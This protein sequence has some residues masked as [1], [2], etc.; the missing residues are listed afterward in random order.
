MKIKV[1]INEKYEEDEIIIKCSKLSE[2][3]V[4]L[5]QMISNQKVKRTRANSVL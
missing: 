3:I 4:K 2:E 5:Q 1:D